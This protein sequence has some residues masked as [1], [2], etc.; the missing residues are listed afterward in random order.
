MAWQNLGMAYPAVGGVGYF[1][2]WMHPSSF[3]GANHLTGSGGGTTAVAAASVT[4]GGL[5]TTGGETVGGSLL[6]G[7]G[8]YHVSITTTAAN[9]TYQ[10]AHGLPYTP[11]WGYAVL[12]L[13][14]AVTPTQFVGFCPADTNATNIALNL[15]AVG[16]YDVF[17]A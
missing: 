13:A 11:T 15:G 12:R 10:I 7:T 5:T 2:P 9:Q 6:P 16:T 8:V 3:T 4:P 1:V 14:E 17:Y